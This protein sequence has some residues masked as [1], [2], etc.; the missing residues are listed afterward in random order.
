[1]SIRRINRQKVPPMSEMTAEERL[2]LTRRTME[3]PE[4]CGLGATDI[5]RILCL[6]ETVK[7]RTVSRFREG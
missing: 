3:L 2:L 5:V 7:A 6:P 4:G 1:M